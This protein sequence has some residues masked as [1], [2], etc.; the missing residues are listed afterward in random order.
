MKML[1]CGF[2]MSLGVLA[3]GAHADQIVNVDGEDYFLSHLTEN[4]QAITGDPAAQIA[5]FSA[6]SKLLEE[7]AVSLPDNSEAVTQALDALRAVAEYQDDATGLSITGADCNIQIVY[8]NNYFHIS[9]RNIST[10]D[11]FSAKFDASKLRFDQITEVRGAQA[12]L[13]T[14]VLDVG[15][16]AIVSGNVALDSGQDN[17]TPRSPD[18]TMDAYANQVVSE[19]QAQEAQS[20]DFVL[21]HP[22]RNPANADIWGAF[23]EFVT[24]CRG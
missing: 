17:F 11:L 20:F 21:V 2:A 4:C 9:R 23:E 1:M 7:Q 3:T 15:A 14:G 22:Q 18:T 12:P 5:C 13:V 24:T 6:L 16:N 19:L 8:Y 10:I